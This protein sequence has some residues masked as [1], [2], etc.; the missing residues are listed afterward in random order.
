LAYSLASVNSD[1]LILAV[2]GRFGLIDGMIT[3][4]VVVAG[5]VAV[6]KTIRSEVRAF[7]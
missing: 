4:G 2:I 1:T 5:I 3:L 7:V 6:Q